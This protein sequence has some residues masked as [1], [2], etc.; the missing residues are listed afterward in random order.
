MDQY[1]GLELEFSE[2]EDSQKDLELG[3]KGRLHE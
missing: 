2:A 3:D 1:A